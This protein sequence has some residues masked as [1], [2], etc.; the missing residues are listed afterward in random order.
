MQGENQR[1]SMLD[2][3]R[4]RIH[5]AVQPGVTAKEIYD[6]LVSKGYRGSFSLVSHYIADIRK[7]KRKGHS[8]KLY[9][10]RKKL[11]QWLWKPS[12]EIKKRTKWLFL[13][14]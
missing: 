9:L 13:D 10:S 12:Q 7:Q 14:D 8:N 3:Y 2:S 6:D 4:D 11:H 1:Q 5:E